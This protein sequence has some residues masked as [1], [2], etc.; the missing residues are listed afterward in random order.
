[1][2]LFVTAKPDD[3]TPAVANCLQT[4][5]CWK[6]IVIED[7]GDKSD[8]MIGQHCQEILERQ[9]SLSKCPPEP[10]FKLFPRKLSPGQSKLLLILDHKVDTL[11]REQFQ[12]LVIQDDLHYTIEDVKWIKDD[13]VQ[14]EFPSVMFQ[15]TMIAKL[16]LRINETNYGSRQIKLENAATM[17]EKAWQHCVDPVTVLSE[18]FDVRFVNHQDIDEFLSANLEKRSRIPDLLNTKFRG[19]TSDHIGKDCCECL[20]KEGCIFD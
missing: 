11:D 7:A 8:F 10:K 20:N 15:S 18:A 16:I 14:V 4:L 13:L 17:L 1:M 19:C 9:E 2:G 12:L 3:I 5:P 6:T